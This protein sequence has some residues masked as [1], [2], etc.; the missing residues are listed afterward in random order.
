MIDIGFSYQYTSDQNFGETWMQLGFL[1]S[2]YF[3]IALRLCPV[4][5]N[6]ASEWQTKE[7]DGEAGFGKYIGQANNV[8]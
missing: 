4:E 1:T 8:Y 7:L 6:L 5:F 2:S 3:G